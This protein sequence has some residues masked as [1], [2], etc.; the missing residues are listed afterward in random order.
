MMDERQIREEAWQEGVSAAM[1]DMGLMWS[2]DEYPNPYAPVVEY[3]PTYMEVHKALMKTFTE[4]EIRRYLGQ[5]ERDIAEYERGMVVNKLDCE[6]GQYNRL[7]GIKPDPL[8]IARN[9]TILYCIAVIK[10]MTG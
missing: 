5:R 8:S 9:D 7:A 4:D 1:K 6:R 2:L 3:T 10:R